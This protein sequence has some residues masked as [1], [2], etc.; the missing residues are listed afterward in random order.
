MLCSHLL[1]HLPSPLPDS[2][3]PATKGRRGKASPG[4]RLLLRHIPNNWTLPHPTRLWSSDNGQRS[5]ISNTTWNT[6]HHH[7]RK[8]TLLPCSC[9]CCSTTHHHHSSSPPAVPLGNDTWLTATPPKIRPANPRNKLLPD[10]WQT[11]AN[12]FIL[13]RSSSRTPHSS[14]G[15]A[16]SASRARTGSSSSATI[17]SSRRVGRVPTKHSLS[18]SP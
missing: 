10:Q 8:T 17:A 6:T 3:Q 13:S 4:Q 1:A 2:F 18:G 9:F 15:T 14:S 11:R 5:T 16:A 12:A 7:F